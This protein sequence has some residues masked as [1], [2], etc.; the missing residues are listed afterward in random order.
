MVIAT[1]F[2]A[3]ITTAASVAA[4][5]DSL[6]AVL[7]LS[8]LAAGG[9]LAI[10]VMVE[11]LVG[12][13]RIFSA[14]RAPIAAGPVEE[15]PLDQM[16][17]RRQAPLKVRAARG[18][19]SPTSLLR[20][21]AGAAIGE[22][23][24]RIEDRSGLGET[25]RADIH[26]DLPSI[27]SALESILSEMALVEEETPLS[28]LVRSGRQK[29]VYEFDRGLSRSALLR[30]QGVLAAQGGEVFAGPTGTSIILPTSDVSSEAGEVQQ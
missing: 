5:N 9:Y 3:I 24:I 12:P 30:A 25:E 26:G 17:A 8:A 4:G 14:E 13:T 27:V 6:L 10:H 7:A 28:I 15:W 22:M 11:L 21:A 19:A 1:G 23:L 16:V 2:V 20:D 18:F 29:I